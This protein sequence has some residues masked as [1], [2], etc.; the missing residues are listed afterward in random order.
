VAEA[1]LPHP[2]LSEADL[3]A[4]LSRLNLTYNNEMKLIGVQIAA[5][6]VRPGERVPV[7]A[8]WQALKPMDTNY[9]VFVH[10]MGRD[11][12]NVGQ[13]NTYPGLGL[14]PTS[15][16]TPGHIVVDTYSVPV[17]GGSAAPARLLVNMGLYDFD[18]PGRPGI[19]PVAPDGNPALPTVGQ[20]KLVPE[21]WPAYED[22][23]PLAE[24]DDHIWLLDYSIHD[25][26]S[27]DS[28]CQIIFNW[29]AQG[30]PA[31]DYTVFIQLWRDGE[32]I[33]GFDTPPLNNDYPT[34]L[35]A[36]G[37]VIIDPHP[38]DLSSLLP[39]EYQVFAGLYNF[40]SGERL[41]ATADGQPRPD[42]AVEL[43]TI[44]IE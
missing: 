19:Q 2:L 31:S 10:L 15:T 12:T 25:C 22:S 14:R 4:D 40:T 11:Y 18:E 38:L 36:A 3:P 23:A 8:Y 39:G 13:M 9:S 35:W 26:P 43:G 17:N 1:Y 32:F 6:E 28:D 41:S 33:V 42:S 37:E 29:L 20:L 16:L 24:F 34:T 27:G 30:R 21:Q 7:T 44:R 5:E